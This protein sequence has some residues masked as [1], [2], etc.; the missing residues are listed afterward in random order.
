MVEAVVALG[1]G[2]IIAFLLTGP[3]ERARQIVAREVPPTA[4]PSP[5]G[6][7]TAAAQPAPSTEPRKATQTAKRFDAH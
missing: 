2:G 7:P 4:T 3:S 5:A 1:L 6:S